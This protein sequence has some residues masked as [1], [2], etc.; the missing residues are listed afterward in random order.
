MSTND[1]Q[2]SEIFKNFFLSEADLGRLKNR[3]IKLK[4]FFANN[5]SEMWL[6]TKKNQNKYLMKNYLIDISASRGNGKKLWRDI[7]KNLDRKCLS[8]KWYSTGAM[9]KY[10]HQ[11]KFQ[12]LLCSL[13]CFIYDNKKVVMNYKLR[14][15][16]SPTTRD[17]GQLE[18]LI[19]SCNR[20]NRFAGRNHRKFVI[21]KSMITKQLSLILVDTVRIYLK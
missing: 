14:Q 10:Y 8:R 1:F 15:L 7:R 9:F 18:T 11:I 6:V 2:N 3:S 17:F 12:I 19:S 5:R 21:T 13:Q 16:F 20:I 4:I